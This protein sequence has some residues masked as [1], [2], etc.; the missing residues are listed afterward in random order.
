MIW[1]WYYL[2]FPS[3]SCIVTSVS[4]SDSCWSCDGSWTQRYGPCYREWGSWGCSWGERRP[5][6]TPGKDSKEIRGQKKW[7]EKMRSET[8]AVSG[9]NRSKSGRV[10]CVCHCDWNCKI[11]FE[12]VGTLR[13]EMQ[14]SLVMASPNEMPTVLSSTIRTFTP[15]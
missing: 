13:R 11:K 6:W 1:W 9:E 15:F 10:E 3:V 7:R 12:W 4:R 5:L 2:C 14:S 8:M